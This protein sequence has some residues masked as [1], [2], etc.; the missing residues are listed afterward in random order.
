MDTT[1]KA[2]RVECYSGYTYTQEPTAVW[3]QE[4]RVEVTAVLH[5][6]REPEG[7]AFRVQLSDGSAT[8]LA[9]H[10]AEDQWFARVE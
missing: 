8:T 1:S 4:G 5:R 2:V 6:W 10:E 9:Y 3:M 7:P